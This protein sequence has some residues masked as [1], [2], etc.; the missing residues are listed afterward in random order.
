MTARLTPTLSS[1]LVDLHDLFT[2]EQTHANLR[3]NMASLARP[4][5]WT[6]VH[7]TTAPFSII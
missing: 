4:Q 6:G 1:L 3:T 2:I 7:V 5:R